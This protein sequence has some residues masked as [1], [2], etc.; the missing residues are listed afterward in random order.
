MRYGGVRRRVRAVRRVAVG[1]LVSGVTALSIAAVGGGAA[2]AQTG[3]SISPEHPVADPVPGAARFDQMG[4]AV[5]S[6]GDSYLVVWMHEQRAYRGL[7]GQIRASRLGSDGVPIDSFGLDISDVGGRGPSVAW[8]NGMYLVVWAQNIPEYTYPCCFPDHVPDVYGARVAADGTVLDPGGFPISAGAGTHQHEPKVAPL[9]DGFVVTFRDTRPTASGVRAARVGAAG[10]VLD[11]EG[12][13]VSVG[14]SDKEH[15][16]VASNAGIA[17]ISWSDR[18]T[19]NADIRAKRVGADGVLIDGS[20]FPVTTTPSDD[21]TP[22]VAAN[23]TGFLVSWEDN[24]G[25]VPHVYAA[26][27]SGGGSVL[28]HG[29]FRVSEVASNRPHPTIASDGAG[30]LVTWLDWRD[31]RVPNEVRG[32][33]V[34]ADGTFSDASAFLA[35]A[36]VGYGSTGSAWGRNG[37]LVSWD[38]YVNGADVFANLLPTSGLPAA[39]DGVLVSAEPSQQLEPAAAWDGTNYLVAW[40]DTRAGVDLYA[41]R[42]APDGTALDGS[43]F[44]ISDAELSQVDARVVWNGTD[45]LVVWRDYRTQNAQVYAARVTR[46]GQVRDPGGFL[47]SL[48]NFDVGPFDVT[49]GD[50]EVMVVWRGYDYASGEAGIYA[51]RVSVAGTVV[52]HIPLADD[53][54]GPSVAWNGRRYLVSWIGPNDDRNIHAAR[55]TRGRVDRDPIVVSSGPEWKMPPETA[56]D[57]SNFFMAW[58][59]DRSGSMEVFGARVSDNGKVLDPGGVLIFGA[60]EYDYLSGLVWDDKH[61]VVSSGLS[62]IRVTCHAVVVDPDGIVLDTHSPWL[63][64]I[65]DMAAGPPGRVALLLNRSIPEPPYNSGTHAFI[66]F[67]DET[68]AAGTLLT[69]GRSPGSSSGERSKD[70]AHG[71]GRSCS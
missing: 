26:R 15:P 29:G 32:R 52:D 3:V 37:Y 66:R 8:N 60:S 18:R 47:V 36:P 6:D 17:L 20:S 30:Y 5:A 67:F 43:G 19:G 7:T 1:W 24:R 40:S 51:S 27:V 59:D 71:A 58:S 31:D 64:G 13:D 61:Y 35:G 69:G 2:L 39:T 63:V 28:D 56:S 54:V 44:L 45:H 12:I 33:R 62:L 65:T 4:S 53:G 9:G 11:P 46:D 23:G 14:S 41:G 48:P 34:G 50:S 49:A 22:T 25:D 57:G 42:V 55:I 38:Q 21:R 10:D 70:P 68:D 16:G